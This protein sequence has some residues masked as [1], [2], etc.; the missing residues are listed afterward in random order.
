MP[1][2][3][4]TIPAL[5]QETIKNLLKDCMIKKHVTNVALARL[6]SLSI[7]TINNMFNPSK[8][9]S[10]EKLARVCEALE[11]PVEDLLAGLSYAGPDSVLALKRRL[12]DFE[13]KLKAA[14]ERVEKFEKLLEGY[15]SKIDE[16]ERRQKTVEN[17]LDGR[18]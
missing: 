17:R 7:G 5:P 1:R 11:Y 13:T 2:P 18:F 6:T 10:S 8:T 4:G 9:I 16:Y 15:E 14:E 12:D 3:R